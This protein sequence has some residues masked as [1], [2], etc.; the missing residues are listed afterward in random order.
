MALAEFAVKKK[1]AVVMA[2]SCL[3]L[4]GVISV[5]SLP[6]EY[7]PKIQFPQITVVTD[8]S[9]AA[10]EE[11]ET[12]ITRPIEETIGAVSGIK[13]IESVSREGRSTITA[14]FDWGQNIDFAALGIREKID[15]VKERLPKESDDPIVLKVN[16]L[17]T[18]EMLISVT[19]PK[20]DP[21]RLKHLT[22]KMLKDRLEKVEGVASVNISGGVN[23]D[24]KSVV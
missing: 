23:R 4:L 12:L 6:Q 1:V 16:P 3:I 11:I 9:N 20:L 21:V 17:A 5:F 8:Y 2:T 14:S 7:F 10:P 18:P 15:L 13:R 24:R 22:E 19:G